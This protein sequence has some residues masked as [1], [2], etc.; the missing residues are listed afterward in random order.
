[1]FFNPTPLSDDSGAVAAFYVGQ[2]Q[3]SNGLGGIQLVHDPDVDVE[4]GGDNVNIGAFDLQ[5]GECEQVGLVVD[6]G[7][8]LG[9]GGE[10]VNAK[11]AEGPIIDEYAEITADVEYYEG[12]G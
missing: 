2:A 5:L 1:V 4:I 10:K 3:G 9:L 6:T 7:N 8:K 11:E 12:D